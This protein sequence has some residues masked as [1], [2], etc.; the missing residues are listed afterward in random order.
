VIAPEGLVLPAKAAGV[1]VYV[2]GSANAPILAVADLGDYRL[3]DIQVPWDSNLSTLIVR[4][5]SEKSQT[6]I[7]G[8]SIWPV[9]FL[10][11]ARFL[12]ARHVVDYSLVTSANP[13]IPGEWIAA[14]ASNLGPVTNTPP[15]GTATP[16]SPLSNLI[17]VS[18]RDVQAIPVF[19]V[20]IAGPNDLPNYFT[21][22]DTNFIGL[23]PYTVGVYQL[24][25]RI[26]DAPLLGDNIVYVRKNIDC[27]FFFVSTC[28]R[29]FTATFSRGAKLPIAVAGH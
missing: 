25:F 9:F 17:P 14:Y 12:V 10:D 5:G 16:L 15:T 28:G 3:I 23:A 7:F 2:G 11:S 29:S 6:L 21:P 27:G 18:P 13:A 1:T 22:A 8:T 26:P 24:N 19:S 20:V 4:Q